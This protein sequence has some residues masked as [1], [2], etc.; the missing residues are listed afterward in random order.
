[1]ARYISTVA[2]S[3][4]V[5]FASVS[6]GLTQDL[7][8]GLFSTAQVERGAEDYQAHCATCHGADLVS[9]DAEAPTLT[10]FTFN[11]RWAGRTLAERHEVIHSTMPVSAP[12]SLESQMVF[13][14]IAFILATNGYEP[15]ETELTAD[16]DLSVEVA[17]IP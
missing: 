12:G 7:P 8:A 14:I 15:G 5:T 17:R 6:T 2:L 3:G 9:T 13:D 1:L 4:F 16:S 10:G 11:L